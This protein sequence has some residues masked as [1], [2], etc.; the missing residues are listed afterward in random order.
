[1]VTRSPLRMPRPRSAA[2][3]ARHLVQQLRVGEDAP[4]AALVEV[5]ERGVAAAS[6]ATWWSSAL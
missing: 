1:M 6:V 5:D 2:A 3:V 4:L